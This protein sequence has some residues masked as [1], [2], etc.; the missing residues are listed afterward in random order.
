[1]P[2]LTLEGAGIVIVA[3]ILVL[4]EVRALIAGFGEDTPHIMRRRVLDELTTTRH[5][6]R[7][8]RKSIMDQCRQWRTEDRED[9]RERLTRIET[10]LAQNPRPDN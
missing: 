5:A 7:E 8:E 3:I 10:K 4:R 9:L 1:M 2:E 6:M